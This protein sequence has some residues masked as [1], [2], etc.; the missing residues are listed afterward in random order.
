MRFPTAFNAPERVVEISGE[1]YFEVNKNV[2]KPFKAII[3]SGSSRTGTSIRGEVE[4]LGTHFNIKAY[5]DD[6]IQTTLTK[7]KLKVSA[8]D[9]SVILQP[10]QQAVI[11]KK[12]ALSKKIFS[13]PTTQP[14]GK[15]ASSCLRMMTSPPSCTNWNAG[16]V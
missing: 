3:I 11:N 13:Q 4:V 6:V 7:G 15:M 1:A 16:M 10:G 8:G 12:R 14:D 5:D 2:Q 9:Q